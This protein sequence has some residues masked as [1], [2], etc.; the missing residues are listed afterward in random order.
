MSL[1]IDAE[2]INRVP[3]V[4]DNNA[5]NTFDSPLIVANSDG[6]VLERL[7]D[8]SANAGTIPAADS[9]DNL[10]P[11][12]VVGNKEDISV[13]PS[14]TS[15]VV[16]MIKKLYDTVINLLSSILVLTETGGTVTTD[17]TEQIVYVH[18]DPAGVF[19]PKIVQIDFTNQTATETIIVR[20]YYRLKEGGTVKL[21]DETAFTGVQA[22]PL[23]TISL[24]KN[25]FGLAI[26]MEKS[27]GTNKAYDFEAI[28]KI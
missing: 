23:K 2:E 27:V 9:T 3:A 12:D 14:N 6:S 22:E 5:D 26:T 7:E 10:T 20:E 8:I 18:D 15:S 21:K 1:T 13:I 17:G 25:R 19:A 4:G 24:E 28:Y 11:A 16:G